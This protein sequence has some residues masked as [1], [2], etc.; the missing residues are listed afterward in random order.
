MEKKVSIYDIAR[1]LGISTATVSFVLNG[2][3]SEKGISEAMEKK[4]AKYAEKIGYH[5]NLLAKSLRTG[6]SGIIGML[7]EGISDPFFASICRTVEELAYEKGYKVFFASTE[8]NPEKAKALIKSFRE[9]QVDGFIIA[10]TPEIQEEIQSLLDHNFPMVL[11]DRYFPEL[12]TTNVI[13]DNR[14]GVVQMIEHLIE[15]NCHSIGFITLE[16]DQV[17][18]EERLAGY[19]KTVAAHGLEEMILKVAFHDREDHIKVQIADFLK[20]HPGLDGVLF[21]TNYLTISGLEVLNRQ[22]IIMPENM[23]VASFD[24]NANF[25]LF[26]PSISVV[27]QPVQA[28]SEEVI[29]LL[30]ERLKEKNKKTHNTV[31]LSTELIIRES[32]KCKRPDKF[33]EP[34]KRIKGSRG[35]GKAKLI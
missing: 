22:N 4:V 12:V 9:S 23:A 11:F 15:R 25:S 29:R 5:P 13:V 26:S 2:K 17:Q 19:K 1:D 14:Q 34:P 27:A 21:A 31:I 3:A 18:M 6:K 28:I 32:T 7:V 8:N 33:H 30:T 20:Q 35:S 10:P 16:S 24:D